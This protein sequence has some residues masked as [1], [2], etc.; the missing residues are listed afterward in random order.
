[1]PTRPA[2][3]FVAALT[4]AALA[5]A[6]ACSNQGEGQVCDASSDDC[7]PGLQCLPQG[8]LGYRC[9]PPQGTQPTT[10]I[11][12]PNHPGVSDANVPP[13]EGGG[14][15]AGPDSPSQADQSAAEASP[16]APAESSSANDASEAATGAEAS[17]GPTE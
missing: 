10:Q 1:M 5:T 8:V 11:C 13:G 15:E 9:C 7:Q 12:S 3:A 4:L 17:D 2:F 16:D 6:G 14:T